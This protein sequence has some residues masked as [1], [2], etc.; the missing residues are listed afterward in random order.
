M[1]PLVLIG[2]FFAAGVAFMGFFVVVMLVLGKG[3]TGRGPGASEPTNTA[4][5]AMRHVRNSDNF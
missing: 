1:D 2:V 4:A 3:K 5:D